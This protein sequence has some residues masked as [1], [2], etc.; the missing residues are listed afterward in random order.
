MH[1]LIPETTGTLRGTSNISSKDINNVSIDKVFYD[2]THT[3]FESKLKQSEQA[4]TEIF[5]K[6]NSKS[7]S[8]Q[9]IPSL[10]EINKPEFRIRKN[11]L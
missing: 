3:F 8:I 11:S 2:S 5:A 10:I 1:S 7:R 4:K 6:I 9:P